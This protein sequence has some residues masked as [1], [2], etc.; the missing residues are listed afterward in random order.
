MLIKAPILS[1]LRTQAI[2]RMSDVVSL[3]IIPGLGRRQV[4]W[5]GV[6]FLQREGLVVHMEK[7]RFPGS[8]TVFFLNQ[9]RPCM[10]SRDWSQVPR[11]EFW[12]W[13]APTPP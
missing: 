1:D 4:A 2:T 13:G 10:V 11:K 12:S 3:G 9:P 6:A 8:F 7:Q 5:M